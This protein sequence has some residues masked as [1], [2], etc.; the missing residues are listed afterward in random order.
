MYTQH[1]NSIGRN[2]K[3]NLPF[4]NAI[5]AVWSIA[6]AL[7]NSIVPIRDDLNSSLDEF[8]Y[9]NGYNITHIIYEEM[10][11]LKFYGATVSEKNN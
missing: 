2:Y 4:A 10:K 9:P 5:D 1:L 6:L 7:N 8:T 3:D 11:R